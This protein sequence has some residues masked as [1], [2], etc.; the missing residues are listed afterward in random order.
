MQRFP[1]GELRGP[2]MYATE[3][4]L[5]HFT[6]FGDGRRLV[7]YIKTKSVHLSMPAKYIDRRDSEMLQS[8]TTGNKPKKVLFG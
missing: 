2:S 8:T 6:S 3:R 1:T 7:Y 5:S 4:Y